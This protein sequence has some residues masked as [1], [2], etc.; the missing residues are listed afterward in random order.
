VLNFQTKTDNRLPQVWVDRVMIQA[1]TTTGED[2]VQYRARFRLSR[3][4]SS[5]VLI[6]VPVPA[7]PTVTFAGVQINNLSVTSEETVAENT[8]RIL[9]VPLPMMGSE[10]QTLE[11]GYRVPNLWTTRGATRLIPPYILHA[12]YQSST[13]WRVQFDRGVVPL[14]FGSDLLTPRR[15]GWRGA[16]LT[17]AAAETDSELEEWFQI[18]KG[19]TATAQ[20]YPTADDVSAFT[21]NQG[22]PGPISI[23]RIP[24]TAW[25]IS[26]AVF[27][28]VFG[29]LLTRL[30][31]IV[32]GPTIA[33]V[34]MLVCIGMLYWP[35]PLMRSVTGIQPGIWALCLILTGQS[36][37]RWYHQRRID[38]LPGFTRSRVEPGSTGSQFG[39]NEA[40]PAAQYTAGS[41]VLAAPVENAQTALPVS[42]RS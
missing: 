15:W 14:Y 39:K 27:T 37:V 42:G 17:P 25:I 40:S 38:H 11:I 32:L 9:H 18:G 12:T 21:G 31:S 26:G 6:T 19:S 20:Q 24:W 41:D 22:V 23:Y 13:R 34:G 30:S 4:P 5:G 2:S 33:V 3:W 16:I 36:A 8:S 7:T 29:L 28:L 10:P 35:Q 1:R